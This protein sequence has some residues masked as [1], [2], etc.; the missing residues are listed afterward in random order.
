MRDLPLVAGCG[1]AHQPPALRGGFVCV[2]MCLC[3]LEYSGPAN[4]ATLISQL[5]DHF[6]S[7]DHQSC[8][9][10]QSNY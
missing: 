7:H 1:T 4:G 8:Q 6:K 3:K 9:L 10:Y 2:N 5:S